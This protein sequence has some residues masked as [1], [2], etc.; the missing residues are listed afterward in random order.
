MATIDA[1]AHVIE[2]ERT[3]EYMEETGV[4]F[5]PLLVSP[6]NSERQ[7]WLID[8]RIFSRGVNVN[9]KIPAAVREMRDIEGRLT[10]MDELEIDIQVLYPSL[11]LRPLTGRPEIEEALCR[12]Y[13]RWLA[14]ICSGAKGRLR[15]V[16]VLPLMSMDVALAEA[17]V[18]RDHG[19]CGLFMRGLA[20]N[21]L[22]SDPY[23]YPLYE[24]AEGLNL[25][26]CVHAST[27]NFDWVELFQRESGFAKFKLPVLTAFHSIVH[28]EIPARFPK[29]RFGF[30]EVRSQWVPYVY[31]ELAKRFEM[32]G[33]RL[34]TEML[35]EN[36][37]YVA[38]QTDDDL[39]YV[40]KYAGED[41]I[42]IGSDYGHAD[43]SS[44]IEALRKLKKG[45]EIS[46]YVIDK[47]LCDNPKALYNL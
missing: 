18:A 29:L 45:G 7:F 26:I 25:P 22:L 15:W 14:D 8:G 6:Q 30:I 23:F 34:G 28:D 33:R 12:S 11:F 38:C 47:I 46:P 37:L 24:E 20:D 1:D 21:K 2:T 44:E 31:R 32:K 35:R 19:A 16:A 42:V 10:H 41:N 3:W 27:G 36:R 4:N 5:R 13:N 17:R 39:P 9:R 43:T 40:L